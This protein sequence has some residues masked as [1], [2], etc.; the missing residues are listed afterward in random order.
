MTTK[1][2]KIRIGMFTLVTGVL[3]AVTLIAFG[4][5][6]F[7]EHRDRYTIVVDGTVYGLQDGA[8]VFANGIRVGSV[9]ELTVPQ[10]DPSKVVVTIKVKSGTPVRA[11][12]RAMLQTAGITG[13]KVIDLRGGTLAAPPLPPGSSIAQG[14]T[15]LDKIEKQAQSIVDQSHQLM[16]RANRVMDT[17][18]QWRPIPSSST[19]SWRRPRL[20][21]RT[22]RTRARRCPRRSARTALPS[23]RRSPAS[24]RRRSPHRK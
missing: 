8:Q 24:A 17:T 14:D 2:Q 21:R 20:R 12:T 11:D 1:A 15:T 6:R 4:G 18:S 10:D 23:A 3:A 22:S 7:W 5:I 19:A 13:L 16:T 9:E